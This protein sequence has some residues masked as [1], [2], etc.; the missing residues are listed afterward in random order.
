MVPPRRDYG[1][2]G[3]GRDCRGTCFRIS[4]VSLLGTDVHLLDSAYSDVGNSDTRVL[5][6]FHLVD[7]IVQNVL[8]LYAGLQVDWH[9][10]SIVT[11]T[12]AI[13]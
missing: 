11:L 7:D 3:S 9:I 1:G 5:D 10:E 13:R 4:L 12:S 8:I 6:L 2:L